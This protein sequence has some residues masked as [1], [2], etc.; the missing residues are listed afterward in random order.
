MALMDF[1]KK[2]FIDIIQWTEDGDGTLAWRFPMADMEI[3]NGGQLVV[4]E[5]QVAIFVNEG[6]VA[7]VF[8]PGTHRLTTQ[9]LPVL[10]YLKNWDKLF[11]SPFKSD[12]Y[13][14][15]TR[16]QIDQRWGT[17]QPVAI[18]DKDFGAVRLRAF[19]NYAYRIQDAK[20][21]HRQISGTRERYTVAD[22]EGQLR[23]L[24]LQ[25]ISDAVASSGTPFLDLAANQV[26]FAAALK[27]ATAPAFQALG[28]EL[29]S[30]T[31]QNVSLPEELQKIL[32]QRIGMGII[33]QNM[34]QFMQY[35][36]AQALPE[37]AKGVGAS[38]SGIAGEAV[39]LGAGVALGQTLA[40]TLGQGL[41][42]VGAA[43]PAPTA[44]RP[45]DIVAL[46]EKL[47]DLKAKGILTDEEFAAKKADLL[48]KLG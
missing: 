37:M 18:R 6:Q 16:Q 12:V 28:L 35:Q 47:G 25:H 4:R 32:D 14:F 5:S 26:E 2:Q 48:K 15:S 34:G 7:D 40:Q 39:G 42:G 8:G 44:S 21:F 46:L 29:L 11:E 3:Q 1:I 10:T 36:A 19:G 38:G 45:D 24:M 22:L 33:G 17:S 30:V 20:A 31:M 43:A 13:F 41:A 9:T 23:G 27:N